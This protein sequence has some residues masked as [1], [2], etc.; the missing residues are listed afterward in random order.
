VMEGK[1]AAGLGWVAD[2][3]VRVPVSYAEEELGCFAVW[4]VGGRDVW[5][6]RSDTAQWRGEGERRGCGCRN[7]CHGQTNRINH[8]IPFL[9]EC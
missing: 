7:D 9:R 8:M 5:Y 6:K 4:K 1:G 2:G 3:L